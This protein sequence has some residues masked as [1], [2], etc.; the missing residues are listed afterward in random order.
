MQDTESHDVVTL[1]NQITKRYELL[2]S[3][4]SWPSC[5]AVPLADCATA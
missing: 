2:I 5:S 4:R 3:Q 1:E